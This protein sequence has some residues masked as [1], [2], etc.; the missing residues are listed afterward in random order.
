MSQVQGK[1]EG[2]K[3]PF[4]G[5]AAPLCAPVHCSNLPQTNYRKGLHSSSRTARRRAHSGQA[6]EQPSLAW[7]KRKSNCSRITSATGAGIT[8]PARSFFARA[9][10][11]ANAGRSI[12]RLERPKFRLATLEI[13]AGRAG[14]FS[15]FWKKAAG[16][17]V[18][19]SER[20][21]RALVAA[22]SFQGATHRS[23][24]QPG[25]SGSSRALL[26]SSRAKAGVVS[27]ERR[28]WRGAVVSPVVSPVRRCNRGW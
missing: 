11:A 17:R 10:A 9:G 13:S 15:R 28:Q 21:R 26:R 3:I 20:C 6:S 22:T 16:G 12:A 18:G 5:P 7:A 25:T 19:V 1:S 14:G 2:G 4:R 24:G 8:K 23:A 27:P